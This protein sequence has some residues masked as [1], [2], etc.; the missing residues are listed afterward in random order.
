MAPSPV[1]PSDALLR[2]AAG[3][4]EPLADAVAAELDADRAVRRQ[5]ERALTAGADAPAVTSPAVRA[6]AR[7]LEGVARAAP[8]AVLLE[9]ARANFTVPFAVHAFDVGAGAL[10]SS[11][12]PPGAAAVLVG[13]GSLVGNAARRLQDTARWLNAAAVPGWLRPGEPGYVETGRV[14]L[15]H[16]LVRRS[17]SVP[18]RVEV[19]QLDTA[20]TWLDF[21]LVAP[22]C[23]AVLGFPITEDEHRRLLRYWR[24]LGELLGLDPALVAGVLERR[25]AEDLQARIAALTPPPSADSRRLTAAGLAA[26]AQGLADVTGVPVPLARPAV[27]VVAR[28]LHGRRVSRQLGIG[29]TGGAHLL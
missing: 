23:A 21:T 22:R 4:G 19:S 15:V 16:A 1:L 29:R 17:A 20:R 13:T 26:I 25:D 24:V 14:R 27:R 7:H 18:G 10:V 8:D 11:Y 2:R 5:H 3:T 9:D 12:R 28:A 6:L